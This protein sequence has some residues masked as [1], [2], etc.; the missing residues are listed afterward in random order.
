MQ[1]TEQEDA[2]VLA[3][4]SS[5]PDKPYTRWSELALRLPGRVGKQCRDRWV[6]H[7]NPALCHEPFTKDDVSFFRWFFGHVLTFPRLKNEAQHL[8]LSGLTRHNLPVRSALR[9]PRT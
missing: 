1:W 3:A 4:V 6:N 7:L 5:N 9:R 2:V 8:A